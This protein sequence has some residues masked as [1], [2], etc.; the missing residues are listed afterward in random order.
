MHHPEYDEEG[1]NKHLYEKTHQ[2]TRSL[3]METV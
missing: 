1:I 3:R 2:A